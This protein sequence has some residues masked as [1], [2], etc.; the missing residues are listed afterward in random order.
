VTTAYHAT[1]ENDPAP[2]GERIPHLMVGLVRRVETDVSDDVDYRVGT[3]CGLDRDITLTTS[4]GI[5]VRCP[6]C[7]AAQEGADA[8]AEDRTDVESTRTAAMVRLAVRWETTADNLAGAVDAPRHPNVLDVLRACAAELRRTLV[9]QRLRAQ[10]VGADPAPDVDPLGRVAVGDPDPTPD[11]P[12]VHCGQTRYPDGR[13]LMC[14]RLPH[15]REWQHIA[16]DPERVV[17]VWTDDAT[18]TAR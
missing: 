12:E 17:G 2:G 3:L 4:S 11:C 1:P 10:S 9:A 8:L 16:S 15:P 5:E 14:T 13:G 7:R 6:A 18:V